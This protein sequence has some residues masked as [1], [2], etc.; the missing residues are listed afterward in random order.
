MNAFRLSALSGAGL[1]VLLATVPIARAQSFDFIFTDGGVTLAQGSFDTNASGLVTDGSLTLT[2]SAASFGFVVPGGPGTF[3][4]ESPT[5]IRANTGT[6]IIYDNMYSSMS[7]PTL[8][9][10][11]LGFGNVL[12]GSTYDYVVNLYGNSP[13]NYGIF[14]AGQLPDALN[15]VYNEV[16]GGS[17][18]VT[19]VPEPSTYAAILGAIC[20]GFAMFHRKRMVT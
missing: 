1:L 14:E 20:L 16:D 5:T 9:S 2:A 13:G 19:Q 18:N 17:F 11:G 10:G 7:N 3:N 12:N 15:H 4:I 6:D 8:T